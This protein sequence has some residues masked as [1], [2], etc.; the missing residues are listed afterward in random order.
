MPNANIINE[1]KRL[2]D[3]AN[4]VDEFEFINLTHSLMVVGFIP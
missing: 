4:R 1:L 3:L 2:F